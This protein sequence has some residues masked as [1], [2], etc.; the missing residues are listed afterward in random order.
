MNVKESL[1]MLIYL[2][3]TQF[4][5]HIAM[6]Y[7]YYN[8]KLYIFSYHLPMRTNRYSETTVMKFCTLQAQD[9]FLSLF[10]ARKANSGQEDRTC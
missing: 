8:K 3:F 5:Y 6:R 10:V 7:K 9:E 2:I 1:L 4:A